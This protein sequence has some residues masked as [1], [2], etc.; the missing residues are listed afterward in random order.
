VELK[1]LSVKRAPERPYLVA[2]WPL[3]AQAASTAL[4][5]VTRP[6]PELELG[7]AE[8]AGLSL[9][10]I[11]LLFTTATLIL[12]LIKKGLI[13]LLKVLL[14]VSL[15]YT[16]S[17]S[18]AGIFA[19]VRLPG[20]V[21]LPL[22]AAATWLGLQPG[23]AGNVAKA[24]LAASVA[25][26]FV[27]IFPEIFTLTFLGMLAAYDAYAVFRGPLGKIFGQIGRSEDPLKPLMIAHGRVSMGLGD[28]FAYSLASASST[29]MLGLPEALIPLALLNVGVLLTLRILYSRRGVL[30]GLTLPVLLWLLGIASVKFSRYV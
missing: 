3:L 4:V 5:S 19:E 21:A 1:G 18:L 14:V 2:L 11:V 10:Y 29:R 23:I 20:V 30:P 15:F 17:I 27:S 28:L 8:S 12:Y 13:K 22:A 24:F 9:T 7:A 25:Y 6:E 16:A 26:L